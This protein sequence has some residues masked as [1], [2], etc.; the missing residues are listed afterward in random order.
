MVGSNDYYGACNSNINE[1]F[2]YLLEDHK[3]NE[4]KL[5]KT[6]I[7]YVI[8]KA[9]DSQALWTMNC[10]RSSTYSK[11]KKYMNSK[12]KRCVD[13]KKQ[14]YKDAFVLNGRV[15]KANTVGCFDFLMPKD[16]EKHL[17][18]TYERIKKDW[19]NCNL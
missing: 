12:E 13:A 18:S 14:L 1:I 17:M 6:E 16:Y 4:K 19:K 10:H 5:T 9:L 11:D 2:R 15:N 7:T 8:V 3:E